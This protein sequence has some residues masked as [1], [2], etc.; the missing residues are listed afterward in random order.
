MTAGAGPASSAA[1]ESSGLAAELA[2]WVF[3][4]RGLSGVCGGCRTVGQQ[5]GQVRLS[6]GLDDLF[7]LRASLARLRD[8]RRGLRSRFCCGFVPLA[9]NAADGSERRVWLFGFVLPV[10]RPQRLSRSG[11][12]LSPGCSHG[13][14]DERHRPARLPRRQPRRAVARSRH[15]PVQLPGG[16]YRM[17]VL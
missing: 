15:C 10:F 12:L 6:R 5:V 8:G 3:W 4:R 14:G 11:A 16:P 13:L 1:S 7:G 17:C 9:I 2:Q